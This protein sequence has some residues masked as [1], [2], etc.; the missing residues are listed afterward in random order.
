MITHEKYAVAP[1]EHAQGHAHLILTGPL[2]RLDDA[3]TMTRIR[4][5]CVPFVLIVCAF[6]RACECVRGVGVIKPDPTR[7]ITF[8]A[9]K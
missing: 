7:R 2:L 4:Q 8:F 9:Q 5:Y 6:A 3:S 1:C